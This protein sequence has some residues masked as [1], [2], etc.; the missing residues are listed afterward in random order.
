MPMEQSQEDF[1]YAEGW[2]WA[3]CMLKHYTPAEVRKRIPR[4]V[5][6]EFVNGM[7]D[8]V[9]NELRSLSRRLKKD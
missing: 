9:K 8:R 7:R 1:E 6:P 2:K 3:G 5:A 4:L